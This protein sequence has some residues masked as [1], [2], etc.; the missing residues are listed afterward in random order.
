MGGS[1]LAKGG[2]R[3]IEKMDKIREVGSRRQTN[4]T[5]D[6]I[7]AKLLGGSIL[8]KFRREASKGGVEKFCR[9]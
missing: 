3:S 6:I 5:R 1:S 8:G 9:G 2:G 4:S 7:L